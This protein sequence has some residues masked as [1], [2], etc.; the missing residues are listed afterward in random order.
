MEQ[1]LVIDTIRPHSQSVVI[2]I[3][4]IVIYKQYQEAYY[5]Y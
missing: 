3:V 2:L 1:C 5:Y 4:N